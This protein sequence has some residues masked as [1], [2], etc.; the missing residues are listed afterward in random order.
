MNLRFRK[1][2]FKKGVAIVIVIIMIVLSI[3]MGLGLHIYSLSTRFQAARASYSTAAEY[4]CEAICEEGFYLAQKAFNSPDFKIESIS[5]GSVNLYER[6]RDPEAGP[7]NVD[8]KPTKVIK[9]L[10]QQIY[11]Q[12][13]VNFPVAGMKGQ[14]TVTFD[15]PF[16]NLPN[17]AHEYSGTIITE[18]SVVPTWTSGNKAFRKMVVSRKFKVVALTPPHPFD[19]SALSIINP[20]YINGESKENMTREIFEPTNQGIDDHNTLCK[21]YK[22]LY[23]QANDTCS[24]CSQCSGSVLYVSG[25][26]KFFSPKIQ[27]GTKIPADFFD[28][29][30]LLVSKYDKNEFEKLMDFNYE[31][32]LFELFPPLYKL[33]QT[34][35]TLSK[36]NAGVLAITVTLLAIVPGH[37]ICDALDAAWGLGE[38]IRA[39]HVALELIV[40]IQFIIGQVTLIVQKIVMEGHIVGQIFENLNEASKGN[41][42]PAASGAATFVGDLNS[43][44]VFEDMG[45]TTEGLDGIQAESGNQD[46][47]EGV[48]SQTEDGSIDVDADALSAATDKYG[49]TDS[50]A[51]G[52]LDGQFDGLKSLE[53]MDKNILS[54]GDSLTGMFGGDTSNPGALSEMAS[55]SKMA[56][57]TGIIKGFVKSHRNLNLTEL[58]PGNSFYEQ[59]KLFFQSF[60]SDL[61]NAKATFRTTDNDQV[62]SLFKKY[63]KDGLCGIICHTGEDEITID[64]NKFKGKL[65]VFSKGSINVKKCTLNDEKTD[66]I[67]I[68]SEGNI[69]LKSNKIEASLNATGEPESYVHFGSSQEIFGNILLNNYSVAAQDDRKSNKTAVKGKLKLNPRLDQREEDGTTIK[70]SH[71]R[72]IIS[73][74]V[75]TQE[76]KMR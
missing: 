49:N 38:V 62:K 1:T 57:L 20:D 25:S 22:K 52:A 44:G 2:R 74:A 75:H 18:A 34:V 10:Q 5:S 51:D 24:I 60:N 30:S 16:S 54:A 39:I 72:V 41:F 69:E 61:W 76:V 32:I 28:D 15:G 17:Q 27:P 46:F 31:D 67:T 68:I 13:S 64:V 71:F 35:I 3:I 53:G 42:K 47:T 7:I 37:E 43:S 73:P 70:D 56:L 59:R 58:V 29:K 33:F 23:D 8:F 11:D 63:E 66:S 19:K 45:S 36:V 55:D 50:Y 4:I 9:H 21:L 6:V 40:P 14:I 48:V 65:I 12:M 26:P